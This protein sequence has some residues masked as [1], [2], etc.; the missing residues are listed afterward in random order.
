[1]EIEVINL[2]KVDFKFIKVKAYFDNCFRILNVSKQIDNENKIDYEYLKSKMPSKIKDRPN[3]Y[4][5][6]VKKENED[7]KIMYVG[8]RKYIGIL[9]RLRQHLVGKHELTGSKLDNINEALCNGYQIGVKMFS[10][11]PNAMRLYYEERLIS[12]LDLK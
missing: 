7:W 6:Y 9:E 8:Q 1:M 2:N 5:L 4:G 3:I 10:I 12:E 11:R